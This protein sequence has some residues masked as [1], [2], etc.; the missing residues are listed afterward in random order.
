MNTY[1]KYS[2]EILQLAKQAGSLIMEKYK[3]LPDVLYKND[4]SPVTEADIAANK[5]IVSS[6]QK[7]TPNISIISEEN[8]EEENKSALINAKDSFWL[9]DP[10]DGTKSY[11]NKTGEFTVNIALVQGGI[12]IGGV[13]YI[14]AKGIA[15]F[16]NEDKAFKQDGNKNPLQIKARKPPKNTIIVVASKSHMTH[17]TQQYI[18]NLGTELKLISA[19]SSLKFCMVAE[20]KADIYP[21][22]GNTMEWDT[23]AGHAILIKAGGSVLSP[24]GDNLLYGKQGFV[25]SFFI[26]KGL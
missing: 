22:F 13:I 19:S 5:L 8:S 18:D 7:I 25:N 10:L 11:I 26:A 6:L 12:P 23:A 15:Y 14:P 3:S 21:R 20:G 17:N 2:F 1:N 9:I 16:T 4:K 24:D